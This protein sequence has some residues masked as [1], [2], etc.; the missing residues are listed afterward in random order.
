M[1]FGCAPGWSADWL[2]KTLNVA[3]VGKMKL[4]WNLK[5][6]NEPRQM[7]SLF[8]SLIIGTAMV[9]GEVREIAILAGVS[10]NLYGIDVEKG[11][12]IWKKHF[13]SSVATPTGGCGGGILCPG[14][15]RQRL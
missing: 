10:D 15:R 8:P 6:D 7:H 12:M 11:E 4:L 2:E 14:G 1:I 3:N 5:T 9:K 13:E